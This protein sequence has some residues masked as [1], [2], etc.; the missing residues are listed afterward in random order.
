[1]KKLEDAWQEEKEELESNHSYA[2]LLVALQS[3]S[4]RFVFGMGTDTVFSMVDG[5]WFDG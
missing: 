3:A 4:T 2:A 1:M 5:G